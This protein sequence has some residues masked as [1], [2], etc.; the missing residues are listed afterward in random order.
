MPI[1]IQELYRQIREAQ[2]D[3]WRREKDAVDKI[4]K[5]LEGHRGTMFSLAELEQATGLNRESLELG[6]DALVGKKMYTVTQPG[7]GI[8]YFGYDK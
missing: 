4:Q 1:E 6:L 8:V 3:L 5:L 7:T 2:S